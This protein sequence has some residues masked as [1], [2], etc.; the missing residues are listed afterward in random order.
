MSPGA[1]M[2]N[3]QSDEVVV[4][5]ITVLLTATHS[6][7]I[8]KQAIEMLRGESNDIAGFITGEILLNGDAKKLAIVTEWCDSHAWSV[9]RYDARVG[10]MLEVCLANSTV[11][12]FELYRRRA[13]FV[14]GGLP[15]RLIATRTEPGLVNS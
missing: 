9:S 10:S 11:L 2:D 6:P 3:M 1:E 14:A 7:E 13:R 4:S 12:D 8:L 15:A 5:V